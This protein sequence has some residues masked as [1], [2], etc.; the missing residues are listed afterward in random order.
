[1]AFAEAID[2]K[3]AEGR[4]FRL[5]KVHR[6]RHT[7]GT[8]L[9]MMGVPLKVIQRDLGHAGPESAHYIALLDEDAEEAFYATKKFDARGREIEVANRDLWELMQLDR[10]ADRILPNGW[11]LLPPLEECGRGNA[12][13]TCN[14]FGSDE[15]HEPE[16]LRQRDETV[17]LI[18]V[19]KAKFRER[20]GNEM[21]DENVWLRERLKELAALDMIIAR[22]GEERTKAAETGDVIHAYIVGGG[23]PARNVAATRARSA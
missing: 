23:V 6:F 21:P 4:R 2:L 3:D 10:R 19:R 7:R 18:E 17:Q 22:I 8:T 15:T 1:M 12:C 5:S 9:A 16:L 13:L 11:C 20:Y 14:V